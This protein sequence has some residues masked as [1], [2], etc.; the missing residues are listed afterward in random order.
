MLFI[1]Y[2]IGEQFMYVRMYAC[3]TEAYSA[4][5]HG[6]LTDSAIAKCD[7]RLMKTGEKTHNLTLNSCDKIV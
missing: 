1:V 4:C 2:Y 6:Q 7:E 3:I 5:A